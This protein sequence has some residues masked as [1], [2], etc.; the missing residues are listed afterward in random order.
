MKFSYS[1]RKSVI[2][3][4]EAIYQKGLRAEFT[5][6]I[7]GT[8]RPEL[9]MDPKVADIIG[10]MIQQALYNTTPEEAAKEADSKLKDYF[11]NE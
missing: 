6:E 2:K 4:A 9:S 1:P 8:E 5:N 3:E 11:E 7:Y 10:D